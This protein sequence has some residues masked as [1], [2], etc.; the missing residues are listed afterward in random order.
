MLNASGTVAVLFDD[1]DID[2]D[3]KRSNLEMLSRFGK[4]VI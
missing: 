4:T 3:V 2:T 1:G